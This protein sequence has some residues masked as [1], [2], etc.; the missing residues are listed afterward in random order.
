MCRF[1]RFLYEF[2]FTFG[3]GD[4][5]FTLSFGYTDRLVA[6]RALKIAVIPILQPIH[7]HQKFPIFPIPFVGIPGKGAKKGN[8]HQA[9]GHQMQNQVWQR[10]AHKNC[11][12]NNGNTGPQN[13]RVQLIVSVAPG[14][15]PP[16]PVFE[17]IH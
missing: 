8:T 4:C 12:Y 10:T 11:H 1:L 9:V 6:A 2:F 3:A 13:H 17:T 5:N 16:E 14:H 15:K 7:Q